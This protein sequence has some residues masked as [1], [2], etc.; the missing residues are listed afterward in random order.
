M[1]VFLAACARQTM[2]PAPSSPAINHLLVGKTALVSGKTRQIGPPSRLAKKSSASAA[3]APSREDKQG[4]TLHW[5]DMKKSK[6]N[7]SA[8][9]EFFEIAE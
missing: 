1:K 7:A 2:V 3:K 6:D 4:V 5:K 9:G 8:A